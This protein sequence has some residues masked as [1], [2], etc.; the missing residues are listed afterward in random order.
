MNCPNHAPNIDPSSPTSDVW[1]SVAFSLMLAMTFTWALS[2][3]GFLFG[4]SIGR[5]QATCGIL[6][7]VCLLLRQHRG[8]RARWLSLSCVI[9][10]LAGCLII[11]AITVDLT[12]DGWAYHQPGVIALSHD[13]NPVTE[14]VFGTWWARY[15]RSIGYPS[16]GPSI[17]ALSTTAYP[18]AL[19]ILGAQAVIWGLPLDAGKYPALLL[20]FVVGLTALRAL[21]LRG[22]PNSWA[23]PL[24][25]LTALNPVC[26]VQ[27]T[28]FYV[29]GAL[30]SCL[31]ILIFSL[32][33]Y[34]VTRSRRDLV[35]ALCAALLACNLK[36]TGPVYTALI[37]LPFAV[38]WLFERRLVARDLLICGIAASVLLA[39]SI[40]PYYTNLKYFGS[41]VYPLSEWDVME[42]Q[43][44][45]G[46]LKEHSLKKLLISLTFSNLADRSFDNPET[47]ERNFKNPFQSRGFDEFKKFGRTADLRIGGFGPFFG[48]TIAV[49]LL[50][51]S[52]LIRGPRNGI[53]FATVALGTLLSIVVNP[54]MWW[55]RFVPQMWLLP[56]LV[57]IA[58]SRSRIAKALAL[59]I[60][61][62]MGVTS[63]IA[64]IGRA[65][66]SYV[67]TL[68]Y[69]DNLKT[70][71]DAPLLVDTSASELRFLPTLTYRLHQQGT[72]F[73]V[74]MGQCATPIDLLVIQGC[75][76]DSR[77]P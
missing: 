11:S 70:L 16:N 34:D 1:H 52:L 12:Y 31:A 74:A 37:L 47:D 22:I 13:W 30:G 43:M 24:S 25:L 63:L 50:A 7:A 10:I 58:A 33:S 44:S 64:V 46:F 21:R 75:K 18:K 26:V 56:V 53:G 20:I 32:L 59:I 57:A 73:Q 28:T 66:S 76:N 6:L 41:P 23:Y 36:F 65:T 35:L 48:I 2:A 5:L 72:T 4:V 60:I 42:D 51:A 67:V 61:L 68:A 15:S 54:Q 3:I 55:A 17:D 38:W 9:A 69:K 29:D 14:P 62:L 8:G 49:T 77:G 71:G 40:N 19:W 39:A 27:S 45:T